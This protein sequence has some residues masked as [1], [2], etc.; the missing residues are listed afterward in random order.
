MQNGFIR[1]TL[2]GT[3]R[4]VW[5]PEIAMIRLIFLSA[6]AMNRNF[7]PPWTDSALVAWGLAA[8]AF[9]FSA[10]CL[11]SLTWDG[12]YLLLHTLQDGVPFAPAHRWF[13]WVLEEPVLLLRPVFDDPAKLAVIH[14][15]TCFLLPLFALAACLGMLRGDNARLRIW[16]VIGILL[17]PLPGQLFVVTEINPTVQLA[18]VLFVFIWQDCPARWSPVAVF[19]MLAMATL[20]PAAAP[21][22]FLAAA[23]AVVFAFSG[24]SARRRMLGWGL[25]FAAVSI[26]QLWVNIL[27]ATPYER[28]NISAS[29]WI[30]EAATGLRY[31]LFP[32]LIPLF[33][34]IGLYVWSLVSRR[35]SR[36]PPWLSKILWIAAFIIG[37]IYISDTGG[38]TASINYRKFVVVATLPVTLVA[39]FDAWRLRATPPEDRGKFPGMRVALACP[40]LLFAILLAGMSLSWKSLAASL[41]AR[42]AAHPGRV[43][44]YSELRPPESDSALNH[45]SVTSLSLVLQGW[46]PQKMVIRDESL[47]RPAGRFCICPGDDFPRADRS[48]NLDWIAHLQSAPAPGK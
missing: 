33:V 29:T 40:A 39:A 44:D 16:P 1:F 36:R 34:D 22:L 10:F 17:V 13:H 30:A 11:T 24:R 46:S 41:M 21:L 9:I 31:T 45:W 4:I 7:T 15:L 12:S 23:M 47:Q 42:L 32:A 20:H 18:W 38:W 35:A 5:L 28:A 37:C 43:M 19:A 6:R 14:G 25:I 2:R 3:N 26:A 27:L 8:I 48:F